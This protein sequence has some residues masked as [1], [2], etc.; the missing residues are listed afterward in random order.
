MKKHLYICCALIIATPA[1]PQNPDPYS[2]ITKSLGEIEQRRQSREREDFL[3]VLP[4]VQI[5]G[6]PYTEVQ[7]PFA[8][9][10][11]SPQYLFDPHE[12]QYRRIR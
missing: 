10:P 5:Q 8:D 9:S 4:Q 6:D 1:F 12:G 11:L 7:K 2:A 3:P